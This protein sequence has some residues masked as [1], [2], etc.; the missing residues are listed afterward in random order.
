MLELEQ[1]AGHLTLRFK[2]PARIRALWTLGIT[3]F[4]VISLVALGQVLPPSTPAFVLI[5]GLILL[6]TVLALAVNAQVPTTT[7]VTAAFDTNGRRIVVVTDKEGR[8][9]TEEIAF[10]AVRELSIL[11]QSSDG[12]RS[13]TVNLV[14]HTG[15]T[16]F[17]GRVRQ[18]RGLSL[19][20]HDSTVNTIVD[21]VR[22]ATGLP[23]PKPQ[24]LGVLGSAIGISRT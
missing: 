23:G 11:T 20:A 18:D 15:R 9:T 16:V 22:A 14:M 12:E 7:G 2:Q 1:D 10:D 24:A 5:C 19:A 13:E 6:V 17:F 4:G 8:A 21:A 3:A